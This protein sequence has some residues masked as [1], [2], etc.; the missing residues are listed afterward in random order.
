MSTG[1]LLLLQP[2]V[3]VQGAGRGRFPE[4]LVNVDTRAWF[5]LSST[6]RVDDDDGADDGADD[7][8]TQG[9]GSPSLLQVELMMMKTVM[10]MM[11][12][13]LSHKGYDHLPFFMHSQQ[14]LVAWEEQLIAALFQCVFLFA[15]CGF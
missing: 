13:Q 5:T 7:D 10:L 3:H 8:L 9:P 15:K 12:L 6:G 1:H 11:M 4:C 14:M 2:A